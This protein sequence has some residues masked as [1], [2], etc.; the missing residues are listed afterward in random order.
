MPL[1]WSVDVLDSCSCVRTVCG[2]WGGILVTRIG[3]EKGRMQ[4]PCNRATV[5]G[6]QL[7]DAPLARTL[8]DQVC[9]TDCVLRCAVTGDW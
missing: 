6:C 1:L 5:L 7:H 4:H 2:A 8:S 9:S 3:Q